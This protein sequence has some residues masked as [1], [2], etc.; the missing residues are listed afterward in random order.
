MTIRVLF[1]CTGNSARSQM[2]EHILRHLAGDHFE[3]FSAGTDP[4]GVH[5]L[6]VKVLA[7]LNIDASA[8]ESKGLERFIEQQFDYIITVCDRANDHCPGFPGDHR[9]IHWSFDDPAAVAGDQLQLKAFRRV[10]DEITNR[11]RI[12]IAAV[13]R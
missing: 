11:M 4:Q 10:C 8:A 12:W 3:V 6:T 9:R 13:D 7:E 1:L 2:A 5:P